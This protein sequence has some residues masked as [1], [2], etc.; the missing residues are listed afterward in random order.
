MP[1]IALSFFYRAAAI[2]GALLTIFQL[3]TNSGE[4]LKCLRDATRR[5]ERFQG[6][7]PNQ[8]HYVYLLKDPSANFNFEF[9]HFISVY[10]TTYHW[11]PPTI[12]IRTNA[13]PA[14]IRRAKGEGR[15][16]KE[17]NKWTR[18][19]FSLP[20]IKINHVKTPER[21]QTSNVTIDSLEHKSEFIRVQ[22]VHDLGGVY[23]DFDA[24]R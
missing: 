21:A 7:I 15:E 4:N 5:F 19:I 23:L 3:A 12:Y 13:S 20:N 6:A 24:H 11:R 16:K 10:A 17:A 18:R 1:F 8:V 22:A 2:L 14:T 9:K